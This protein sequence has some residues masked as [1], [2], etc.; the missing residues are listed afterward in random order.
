MGTSG[1]AASASAAAP[2]CTSAAAAALSF[3]P[4]PNMR[5]RDVERDFDV[6][7]P[8]GGVPV[9]SLLPLPSIRP[10]GLLDARLPGVPLRE[11]AGVPAWR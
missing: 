3:E 9:R 5:P 11:P 8:L 10:R 2:V 7:L 1:S 6:D 4:F